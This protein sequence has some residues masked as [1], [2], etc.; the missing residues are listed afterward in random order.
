MYRRS[1]TFL[2]IVQ[3][4]FVNIMYCSC[5]FFFNNY[6]IVPIIL[7]HLQ[8]PID[9]ECLKVLPDLKVNLNCVD[10]EISIC[11]TI[12]K[13]CPETLKKECRFYLGFTLRIKNKIFQRNSRL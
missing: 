1:K 13:M 11:K 7:K 5:L 6:Y 4:K 8:L 2:N 9:L 12:Q 3:N 10:Y